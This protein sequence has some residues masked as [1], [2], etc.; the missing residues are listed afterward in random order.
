MT[1]LIEALSGVLD[2]FLLYLFASG[3]YSK[4]RSTKY[5]GHLYL[6]VGI[7]IIVMS[8]IHMPG[9]LRIVLSWSIISVSTYA[10]FESTVRKALLTS[11]A[12]ITLSVLVD[13]ICEYPFYLSGISRTVILGQGLARCIFIIF[14]K[15]INLLLI[16]FIV[17]LF[18]KKGL[19]DIPFK[20][21]LP[22]TTCQLVSVFICIVSLELVGTV[23]H[24]LLILLTLSIAGILYINIVF[25]VYMRS[26]RTNYENEQQRCLAEQQL[27]TQLSYYEQ[28]K[29]AN[30][31]TRSLWHDIKKQLT[32]VTALVKD[33]DVSQ[34][35]LYLETI[36]KSFNSLSKIVDVDHPVIN[37]ILNDALGK[38]SLAGIT[39]KIDV[40]VSPQL[41]LSPLVLSVI[42]GNTLDNAIRACSGVSAD[43]PKIVSL[44]LRQKDSILYYRISNPYDPEFS[45]KKREGIHVYGLKNVSSTVEQIGG[46]MQIN[47]ENNLYTV[48]IIL[49]L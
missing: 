39:L 32:A 5:K 22:L 47:Q 35:E 31:Q 7:F 15:L 36:T 41:A 45:S 8:C 10:I 25:F 46:T 37:A 38:S 6:L 30:E 18:G 29:S 2:T 9:I 1:L 17:T 24:F 34:A 26:I 21:L 14:A 13:V 11:T 48:E 20:E 3:F 33:S 4:Y 16:L 19:L 28:M 12:F 42:L 44:T 23:S 43:T 49:N 40:F 27:K